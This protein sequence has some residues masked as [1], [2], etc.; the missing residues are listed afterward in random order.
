MNKQPKLDI[1]EPLSATLKLRV[2]PSLLAIFRERCAA[3]P[4][5]PVDVSDQV[6][7]L[8]AAWVADTR[9]GG[10]L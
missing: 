10:L 9:Q 8:M 3:D 7:R 6:R 2:Q 5:G 4:T 1:R